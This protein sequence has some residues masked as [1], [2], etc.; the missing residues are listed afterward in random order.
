MSTRLGIALLW[1]LHFLPL[2]ALRA[3]GALFG[4]LLFRL[5]R[6]RRQIALTNLRLCFPQLS[7]AE[8]TALARAH[9]RAFAQS[10]IERGLLWWASPARLKRLIRI[11]GRELLPADG[12]PV[13]LLAPHFVG[14]DAGWTRLTMEL[15]MASIYANQKNPDF[16][17][18]LYQ[19][20]M[21]F[22]TPLLLS[23]QMGLR[24]VVRAVREGRPFYYL[25]DMDF[26][27]DDS[28]FVPFFGVPTA[29]ITGVPRLAALAGARV[30]PCVTRMSKDGYVVHIYPAW[31]DFPGADVAA[32]TRR[33]NAAIEAWV[34][35]MPEQYFWV[36]K[37][38]KTRP[39]GAPSVY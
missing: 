25:P 16:N 34:G 6:E 17:A 19:G 28:I 33:V 35:E 36:H 26:G 9:F 14:L 8:R 30:L 13:L 27:R 24:R 29:T 20:R 23:R 7:E 22:N 11:E 31:Q 2:G 1:A 5:G 38:F 21:R 15:P 37:R 12:A 4:G 18:A 32:D 39:E 10:F 3:V